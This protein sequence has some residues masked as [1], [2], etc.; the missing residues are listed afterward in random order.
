MLSRFLLKKWGCVSPEEYAGF[1][2]R[3]SGGVSVNP[4]VLN[5]IHSKV[6]CNE[7]YYFKYNRKGEPISAICVWHGKYLAGSTSSFEKMKIDQYHIPH[8]I[9]FLPS[10]NEKFILPFPVKN[11]ISLNHSSVFNST[12]INARRQAAIVKK[13]NEFS[14]KT[15][16]KRNSELR[17]FLDD[18]GDVVPVSAL[19]PSDFSRIYE[20]LYYS[21]RGVKPDNVSGLECTIKNLP[22]NICGHVLLRRGKPCAIDLI[23]SSESDNTIFIEFVNG[24]FDLALKD[25]APGRLLNW[26][27]IKHFNEVA[28]RKKKNI[29]ASFG[30][31]YM[32]Y[33]SLWTNPSPLYRVIA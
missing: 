29:V 30:N 9:L 26:V 27:N 19:S 4:S 18:G 24:G 16:K 7:K 8:G 13:T 25:I 6:E 10:V 20:E 33:K 14:N 28:V 3:T 11:L 21:R 15:R 22:D 17:R 12:G 32:G 5:Y 23:F 31:F 1:F 2:M